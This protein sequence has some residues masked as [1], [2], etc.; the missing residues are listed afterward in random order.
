[1]TTKYTINTSVVDVIK[2]SKKCWVSGLGKDAVFEEFPLG[3]FLHLK[4]SNEAVF[5]GDEEPGFKQ[6]D[7]VR[8][9]IERV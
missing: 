6:G 2:K 7:K 9:T 3:W 8:I 1:M 5:L 4:G